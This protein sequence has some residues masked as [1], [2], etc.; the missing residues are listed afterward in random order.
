MKLYRA[1]LIIF[2]VVV[3]ISAGGA[4][5]KA[6]APNKV[7]AANVK[8]EDLVFLSGHNRGEKDGGIIDEHWSEVGGNSLIGMF[9]YIQQGKVQMYEFLAIEETPE[10]PVL[11]LRHFNPG[12]TA[13]EEKDQVYSYPLIS[14][15]RGEAVFERAD[16]GSKMIFR[17]T[18]PGTLEVALE[19]A[20]KKSEIFEYAHSP[21]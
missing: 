7:A 6:T 16:K 5:S 1:L 15:K 11:R 12:L 10:G 2:A 13:W 3:F 17:L 4:Q 21:E 14:W 9:R 19:R 18:S 8:L 20:G